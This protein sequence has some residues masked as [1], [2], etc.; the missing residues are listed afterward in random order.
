MVSGKNLFQIQNPDPGV[1]KAPSDQQQSRLPKFNSLKMDD[2]LFFTEKVAQN[3]AFSMSK[4]A[5]FPES[6]PLIF[7]SFYFLLHFMLDPDQIRFLNR[8][9]SRNSNAFRFRFR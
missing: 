3:L 4:A 6:W 8:I 7:N 5:Y 9:R 1:K 2:F